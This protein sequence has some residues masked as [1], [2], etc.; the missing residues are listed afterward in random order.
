MPSPH[1]TAYPRLKTSF[2]QNELAQHF[3]PNEVEIDMAFGSVSGKAARL[4]FLVL[5][6]TFQ[7]L[8]YFV[9]INECA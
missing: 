8:G 1:E 9:T 4:C 5:L 3:S 2:T 7:R 6:K